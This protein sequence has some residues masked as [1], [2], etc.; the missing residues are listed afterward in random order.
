M[1]TLVR[2]W[3]ASWQYQVFSVYVRVLFV[4]FFWSLLLI[5]LV[6][7][8]Y[9]F[10][11]ERWSLLTGAHERK[12]RKRR[13]L[14]P[15]TSQCGQVSSIS[16]K[17]SCIQTAVSCMTS[18]IFLRVFFWWW[19]CLT[20]CM[21]LSSFCRWVIFLF[22]LDLEDSQPLPP[23]IIFRV[24]LS[25]CSCQGSFPQLYGPANI[26]ALPWYIRDVRWLDVQHLEGGIACE[27]FAH[28]IINS[29][30][31]WVLEARFA[32]VINNNCM[33]VLTVC[34]CYE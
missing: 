14:T 34:S 15:R 25:L 26:T 2:I 21:R 11:M 3:Y 12:R 1:H 23:P 10:R 19:H 18:T 9:A 5:L 7:C 17:S 28:A 29:I 33:C 6:L 8:L 24:C 16:Y 22:W 4:A 31:M 13:R 32:N 27:C 30:C 20:Q